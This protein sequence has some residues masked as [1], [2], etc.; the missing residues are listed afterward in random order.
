[1][2]LI[3]QALVSVITYEITSYSPGIMI[4]RVWTEARAHDAIM[5]LY[6]EL[7]NAPP[8]TFPF[9]QAIVMPQQLLPHLGST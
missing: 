6:E 5:L 8:E 1:M 3:T 9:R 7:G 4:T 2:D